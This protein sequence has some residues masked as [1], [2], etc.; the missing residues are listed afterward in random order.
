MQ[1][2]PAAFWLAKGPTICCWPLDEKLSNE[3]GFWTVEIKTPAGRV[4]SI[5]LD[6]IAPNRKHACPIRM[7]GPYGEEPARDRE[8]A[9]CTGVVVA[10][11][12]E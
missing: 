3:M 6:V 9:A 12:W 11:C 10:A 5:P 8:H 1:K 4:F 7:S 2:V